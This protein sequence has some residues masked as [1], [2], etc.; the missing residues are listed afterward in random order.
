MKSHTRPLQ[1][2]IHTYQGTY[3]KPVRKQLAAMFSWMKQE[4]MRIPDQTIRS[5]LLRQLGKHRHRKT[6][7]RHDKIQHLAYDVLPPK[8]SSHPC[9]YLSD[10][11]LYEALHPAFYRNRDWAFLHRIFTEDDDKIPFKKGESRK[12]SRQ[13]TGDSHAFI[14]W[15]QGHWVAVWQDI[16]RK[17]WY[18]FD[19]EANYN[20][21]PSCVK[22]AQRVA[23]RHGYRTWHNRIP[24]QTKPGECG[25]FVIYFI[26]H[27][28][29]RLPFRRF[30]QA[31]YR[32]KINDETMT[33][34]HHLLFRD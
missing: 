15:T 21:R 5:G 6:S 25:M 30:N 27:A 29:E 1:K 32:D 13:K 7:Y 4:P 18:Y 10:R 19:S 28:L 20:A 31:R 12:K 33:R 17:R 24:L 23:R 34:Y 9:R 16:R 2:Y 14:V 26:L 8:E 3:S 11:N 22:R